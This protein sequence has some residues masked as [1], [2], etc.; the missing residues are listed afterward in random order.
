MP[1]PTDSSQSHDFC[2]LGKAVIETEQRAIAE[3][4]D[5]VD[6]NFDEACQLL[7]QCR[8]RIILLGMGKSGHIAN[9]I[10]AT[11]ASTGSPSFFVHPGEASHGDLGMITQQDCVLA[12]SYSGLT[13]EII[14]IIPTIKR[15][16]TPLVGLTGDPHSPIAKFSDVHLDVSIH[17]EACPLGLAPTASTTASL[18][19]GDALAIAL[20]QAR[21]FTREDFAR[22]HP[23]G[24]LGTRLLLT[25][26]QLMHQGQTMPCVQQ[27]ASIKKAILEITHKR[28]GMTTI[29]DAN[30]E[31][32]GIYTDGDLRRSLDRNLDIDKTPI[33]EVMTTSFRSIVPGTL[34]VEALR[35][36]QENKITSLVVTCDRKQCL[37]IMHIHELLAA[38]IV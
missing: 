29:V 18:V 31:L 35:L 37:G 33:C 27:N 21:G 32:C 26:D 17:Q 5:R 11:F 4:L 30:S 7:L 12:L 1:N 24:R 8:G 10:A 16:G 13:Q 14:A 20:L 22:T 34:A 3:L 28:L 36:M 9:K 23:G 2:S 19:M 25:V 6:H 38:G 15:L